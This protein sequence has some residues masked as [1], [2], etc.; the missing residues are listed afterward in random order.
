[1]KSQGKLLLCVYCVSFIF[2]LNFQ[3]CVAVIEICVAN[4]N[5]ILKKTICT[6]MWYINVDTDSPFNL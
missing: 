2:L 6:L 4:C 1:M 3:N 5:V